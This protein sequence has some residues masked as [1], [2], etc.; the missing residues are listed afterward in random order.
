MAK[1]ITIT[2]SEI[3]ESLSDDWGGKNTTNSAQTIH[4]TR[5]PAGAEWG[6]TREEVERFIK[7][8][9]GERVGCIRVAQN[10]QNNYLVLGFKDEDDYS[11]WNAMD[12]SDKWG[13]EGQ[14]L[15]VTSA[16]LPSD[17]GDAYSV[18]LTLQS[19]PAETQPSK[20]VT[21][22][23]KGTSTII[24]GTG[25]T[26]SLS[27]T[28]TV[29]IQ[30]KVSASADYVQRDTVDITAGS[31]SYT[32]IDLSPY[33]YD[34]VNYVRMRAVGQNATS[35]WRS[36]ILNVV[37]LSIVPN[38]SFELPMSNTNL[39]LNYL[40]GGA[41]AKTLQ[42]EFG[43]G[44]DTA[45]VR[46]YSY[47]NNDTD[48]SRSLGTTTNT[49]T[50][51]TFEFTDATMMATLLAD[52]VHTVRARL[53]VSDDVKT[54][55]VESQY[56]VVKGS[57]TTPRVIVNDVQT[58]LANWSELKFFDWAAY[59]G[60]ETSMAVVFRLT[61]EDNEETYATWRLTAEDSTKYSLQTQLGIELEDNSVT[62]FYGY[63]HIEDEEG[64]ALAS[65]VFFTFSNSAAYQPTSGANLVISPS[66]RD[67]SEADPATIINSV[68]GEEV[69]STFTGFGFTSDGW[70]GVQKDVDSTASD[71]ETVR[72]LH[73]PAGRSLDIDYNPFSELTD[74]NNT[75]KSM[76]LE[77]DFRTNNILDEDEPIL[78]IGT[79]HAADGEIWGL[80]LLPM[81]V[82][83]LT[84]RM[85]AV[86]DQNAS[87]ADGV[88][89]HLAVNVVY[90]L[91]G[92]N[93]VRL[94]INGI[95]EREFNYVASDR[96]TTTSGVHIVMGNTK[97]DLD[98]FG[99]RCYK[100]ALST[101]EVMQDYK[102]SMS[103]VS[104]K[105]AFADANDILGDGD[106]ISYSKV[107]GKYNLIAHTGHLPKYGDENKGKT[108][109]VSIYINI[110][111]DA[112]HSGT[113][114]NLESSGQGTTAMTY[115]DWNQQYKTTDDSV[116]TA[117]DG[118]VSAAGAGYAIQSGEYLAKKLCGKIN[119]ASGMQSHKLGLC[120]IYTELYKRL[121]SNSVISTPGQFTAYPNARISVYEKPFFFFH[122]ETESD[123][124]TFKYL[125][126]FG[127]GKGDK[128]TFGFNK[129]T[130]PDMLM[131]EG[132][133]NDRPLAL[134]R[135]PWNDDITYS[136]DDEAWMYNSQKQIN[137]GLGVT[138]KTDGKEYPSSENGLAAM[139]A[140]FNF[141][142]LHHTRIEYF[143][144]TLTQ[145]KASSDVS[146]AKMYWM[147]AA[148]ATLNSSQYDLYRWDELT[149]DWV[150]AGVTKS[151]TGSYEK[152]NVRTQY[153]AFCTDTGATAQT[154]TNGQWSQIS[155]MVIAMRRAHFKA[156]ASTVMHVDD[157]LY[158]S[159]FIKFFAGTDNRAKN[160][161]YV[162]DPVTLKVRFW[163]DDLD[164][165]IKTN[166]VGQNRKP[167]YV[168]EHDKNASG[169][170]YWQGEESG[171]YN[172]LEEAFES[173]MTTMMNNMMTGMTQLGGS[174]MSFIEQYFLSTQ[175]Y[176]PAIAYNEQA[177]L[178]YEAAAV[179]QAAGTY[180]NSS[181]QAITQSC[182]S[183]RWSEYQW[184]KDRVMYI[185]SWCEYGEFAGSSSASGGLSWRGTN[186]ATYNFKLTPAKWLY[187]RVG[188]D[189][190]NYP[191]GT[192][193]RV[194]VA[195]GQQME[196]PEIT[197]TS[198]SLISIRGIDYLLDIGD[199]NI[200]LSSGQGTFTI[201]GKRL[202]RIAVN[203]DG[204]GTNVLLATS[205]AISNATNIKEFI[206]RGVGTV[207]GALDL[208]K[209]SRLEE[210]DLRGT[211][212]SIVELPAS[213][214]LT[215]VQMPATMTEL[216]ATAQP[217]LETLTL[218]GSSYL[219]SIEIDQRKATSLDTGM[220]MQSI[221]T[222]K[223]VTGAAELTSVKMQ[224]VDWEDIRADVLMWLV[225]ASTCQ[226]T[227]SIAM[228]AVSGDRYMT[229]AEVSQLIEKFGNIRSTANSLYIDYPTRTITAFSI[230][231]VKYVTQTGTFS[232]WSL[233]VKPTTGNN[234]A[235]V[236]G[237][238]AIAWSF[239]GSNAASA[240]VY[241]AFTDA[242]KGTLNVK[243]LSAAA[244]DLRF[245]I[246]VV[247]TLTDGS[248]ITETKK[249]GFYNRVPRVG[250][251]AYN[252]GS[253]D[254]EYDKSKSLAGAVVMRE[255]VY[256]GSGTLKGYKLWVD[257]K[258]NA[259]VKSTDGTL[260]TAGLPWGIYPDSGETNGFTSTFYGEIADASDSFANGSAVVDTAMTNI[261]STGM[262]NAYIGSDNNDYRDD[263]QDDGFKV[264][265]SNAAVGDF[266][267][268]AK[269]TILINHA[270]AIITDY[271][272][273]PLPTTM[274]E[275]AD[276]MQ[277]LVAKMTEDGVSA[278]ARYLQLYYPAAYACHLYEP[279]VDDGET[280]NEQY[281][282][283]KWMLPAS[284]L[285][286]RIY[287]FFRMS[288]N[289]VTLENGGSVKASYANESPESE[290]LLPL[291]ANIL[292]R[293]AAAGAAGT[294]FI[295]RGASHYWS[296][297]ESSGIGA[298]NVGFHSGLVGSSGKCTGLV[299]RPVAAFTWEL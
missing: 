284:G 31:S 158:H 229:L 254:D 185:S 281:A 16:Q 291:Y 92:L 184:L 256:D 6:V 286:A 208:S 259:T 35:I 239:T 64:N 3:L 142:Y 225:G 210:I 155:A 65:S 263:T 127:A 89:T 182:G 177:R 224:G 255:E 270:K 115:R 15:I 61:D 123:P 226:L 42:L 231:G 235:I 251:F 189:S 206:V 103:S 33:L 27:E 141:A 34:G 77:L 72:A 5:V 149:E 26:E 204:T 197:L 144:G 183:Q 148:D 108:T 45:F 265:G 70:V 250:D 267:T 52:G 107:L 11:T 24:Y 40:I 232:G 121:V 264:F 151:G 58:G 292:A 21:V 106:E 56:M 162:T 55:W 37:N 152:L 179:A 168:E 136:P 145:L 102:A 181:V 243:Q 98:V 9:F 59:C 30:T 87:W 192:S 19:T 171:F 111:G 93:Y 44:L 116:F 215:E 188:S 104:E 198:D 146:T 164:T 248:T 278:P 156:K 69:D 213:E 202:Q 94:F 268:E 295:M 132:A 129:S 296:A 124:W 241:A 8:M 230:A 200:G 271:L 201:G 147:T 71:A 299:V 38:T 175:D 274:T 74:G 297:A 117:D 126:T 190:G 222:A 4:E 178:V 75:G 257:S 289:D 80:E 272:D 269:N 95:I 99:I 258:E 131:V 46:Q 246:Q 169:E 83:M 139:K 67:N 73:I 18:Q 277:A 288:C 275:L 51:I 62:E 218:Q 20:A 279:T 32:T 245:T 150:D 294:P 135:I 154:W 84:Q 203:E 173:E 167:Y 207:S 244:L 252:D 137:F 249:V 172:A 143:N 221:Y 166:N 22:G 17:T 176:F 39:Q 101:T 79:T 209:C 237:R 273:E 138:T 78:K 290:A 28:L 119:F 2:G 125:M 165:M 122:R 161:Y 193:G 12:D 159:C 186:G 253:F 261:G 140:F 282:K 50:G 91:N 113:L 54:D 276:A 194:R 57:L 180:Q 219:T 86:D 109:G 283:G 14:E 81:E 170:Y 223:Q 195:A 66:G 43:T 191:A 160:T 82:R 100:K 1:K 247:I 7:K 53:Y 214:S 262:T 280:L 216:K 242:V 90:G 68:D 236:N 287:N 153:E 187:P 97:S 60:G 36:F 110:V 23:V 105:V 285:L 85:R 227:G 48:C 120:R 220:L 199:M 112:A 47:L 76:T 266:D 293:V 240:S 128:P 96:F 174:V 41:V 196:Y 205:I 49:S 133:N 63:M 130:T 13:T 114:D 118:T 212:F 238:P 228:L 233:S 298:W 25:G 10:E 234:V 163:Q 157:A 88:R 134:F 217:S 29:Q 211:T 260:N